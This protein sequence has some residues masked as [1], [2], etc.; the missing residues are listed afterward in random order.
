[1]SDHSSHRRFDGTLVTVPFGAEN[2]ERTARDEYRMLL[3]EH[4][5]ED[6]LVITGAPTS[7]DTFRETIGEE[8]PGAAI[9]YVTS[10][11]VHATEV[12]NQTDDR[13]ILSD[14]LRRE[15]LH[16]FLADYEWETAYLQRASEQ[17][18]FIENVDAVMSTITWQTATPA[19]TPELRDIVAALDAFHEWL[20]EHDHM[21]RGQ[22]SEDSYFEIVDAIERLE[23]GDSYRSVAQ[24]LAISRQ[25]LSNIHQ[26]P[27]RK[28]WYLKMR[29]QHSTSSRRNSRGESLGDE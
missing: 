7:T 5:P 24:S 14:A 25:G 26:D 4:D 10:P 29:R 2:V 1:M 20:A 18:S 9:P 12:L 15:L 19:D 3:D 17:P 23:D 8:L 11:V 6:V 28:Q 13:V 22:H 27:N 21:E 16:R